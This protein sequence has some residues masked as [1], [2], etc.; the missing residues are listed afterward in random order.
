MNGTGSIHVATGPSYQREADVPGIGLLTRALH[1]ATDTAHAFSAL[2]PASAD[3][4][5]AL[6]H[7][8]APTFDHAGRPE[9]VTAHAPFPAMT[10]A[11]PWV[12]QVRETHQPRLQYPEWLRQG[13]ASAQI[14]LQIQVDER[15]HAD[16]STARAVWQS[17]EPQP[18][19]GVALAA[20][21][22]FVNTAKAALP[23]FGFEPAR[24]GG[25]PV[26]STAALRFIFSI[27]P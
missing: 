5:H 10:L 16:S 8:V 7:F 24:I 18:K 14:T 17:S 11:Q 1:M 22:T 23:K 3:S 9:T 12:E 20:Y 6:L 13:S 26:P 25:C 27:A 4:V 19:A 21:T 2:G 15:G